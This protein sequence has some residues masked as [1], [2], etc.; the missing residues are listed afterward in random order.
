MYSHCYFYSVAGIIDGRGESLS[1]SH[2]LVSCASFAFILCA[3][4]PINHVTPPYIEHVHV[5]NMWWLWACI[6]SCQDVF[7]VKWI[8]YMVAPDLTTLFRLF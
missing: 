4:L 7:N 3:L 2:T 8:D 5:S 6:R 1:P